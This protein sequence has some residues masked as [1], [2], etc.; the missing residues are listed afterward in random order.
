MPLICFLEQCIREL[1]TSSCHWENLPQ[2]SSHDKPL[3]KIKS[4]SEIKPVHKASIIQWQKLRKK[5][6]IKKW[7]WNGLFIK[8]LKVKQ[9][10][11]NPSLGLCMLETWWHLKNYHT[12]QNKT[13]H[14]FAPLNH[15]APVISLVSL[16]RMVVAVESLSCVQLFVTPWITV[17]QAPLSM[18]FSRQEYWS[19]LPFPPP[20]LDLPD[21]GIEP[22]S[23]ALRADSLPPELQGKL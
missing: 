14:L 18:G 6:N 17:Y 21:P 5:S 4:Y 9:N 7:F 19:G 2:G 11:G 3:G 13:R 12:K 20:P 15:L 23:P 10:T 8:A 16:S 1:S 22:R